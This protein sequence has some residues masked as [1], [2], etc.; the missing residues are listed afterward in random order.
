MARGPAGL[1]KQ[2]SRAI[3]RSMSKPFVHQGVKV[4]FTGEAKN[5]RVI[6]SRPDLV[7]LQF[8]TH[9]ETPADQHAGPLLRKVVKA[10][11]KPG[12]RREAVFGTSPKKNFYAYSMDPTNPTR[13]VREDVEG[14]R[15]VGTM[16]DGRFRKVA[17]VA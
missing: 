9:V 3:L 15:T 16:V 5:A 12:V 10:L 2:R 13:M 8:K 4:M 7:M 11:S 14:N 6:T 17:A 1:V